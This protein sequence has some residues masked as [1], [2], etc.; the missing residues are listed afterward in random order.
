SESVHLKR[1]F[2][3][4]KLDKREVIQQLPLTLRLVAANGR[5]CLA[6]INIRHPPFDSVTLLLSFAQVIA[7]CS[8]QIFESG[9]ESV[10]GCDCVFYLNFVFKPFMRSLIIPWF[11]K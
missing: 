4:F 10:Y 9:F 2:F 11:F 8:Q 7:Q 5:G 6:S 1:Q 3:I